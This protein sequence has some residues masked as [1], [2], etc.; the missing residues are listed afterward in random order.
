MSSAMNWTVHNGGLVAEESYPYD[1]NTPQKYCRAPAD[2]ELTVV[3]ISG[4]VDVPPNNKTQLMQAVKMQPVS[5]A[6]DANCDEF[7]NYQDGVFDG[8]SC[9]TSLDHGVLLTGFKTELNRKGVLGGFLRM[10]NSW[11][12]DWGDSGYMEINLEDGKGVMGVNMQASFPTGATMYKNYVKPKYCG[13]DQHGSNKNESFHS[14]SQM[15]GPETCCC[16][17]HNTGILKECTSYVCC[18]NGTKCSKAGVCA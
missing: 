9:G 11:S 6:I 3:K 17:H 12:A 15:T 1:A 4:F 14:C 18:Q 10:K 13:L 16:T 2:P 5:V 8:G 7:Q